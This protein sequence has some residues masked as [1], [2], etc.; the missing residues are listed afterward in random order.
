MG[1]LTSVDYQGQPGLISTVEV[2][3]GDPQRPPESCTIRLGPCVRE[4]EK[5]AVARR[6]LGNR[7]GHSAARGLV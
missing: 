4:C 3:A 1:L 2:P 7:L 5:G 6:N